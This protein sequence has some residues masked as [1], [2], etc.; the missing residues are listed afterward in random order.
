MRTQILGV[1][2]SEVFRHLVILTHGICDA[3]PG[4][5]AR[6]RRSDDRQEY[7]ERLGEHEDPAI[8]GTQDRVSDHHH[9]VADGRGGARR[10]LHG[11]AVV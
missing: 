1:Q 7:C 2:H 8:S 11:V 6:E 10:V 5:H 3:R 4:V 9:H